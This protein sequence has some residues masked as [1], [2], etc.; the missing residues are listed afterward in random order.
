[1]SSKLDTA[2]H[3]LCQSKKAEQLLV[4]QQN[5]M[6]IEL[7]AEKRDREKATLEM[8]RCLKVCQFQHAVLF[9][10]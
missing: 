7:I 3:E 9:L 10:F 4:E 5:Q 6:S 8:K 2:K 1:M